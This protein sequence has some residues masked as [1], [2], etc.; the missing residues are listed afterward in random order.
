MA[1]GRKFV[2]FLCLLA[3][4]VIV[5]CASYTEEVRE[6][7]SLYRQ[8]SYE[9]ALKKLDELSLKEESK[10][11]LLYRLEKAMIL[12]RL[13]KGDEARKLLL[14]A[15]KI[16]DELYTTSITKTAASFIVNDSSTDYEGEDFEKVAIH[17]QLALS[18]LGEGQLQQARVEAKAINSRLQ[19]INQKY[20]ADS[21]NRYQ[22]DAFA[23]YLSGLIFE[24]KGEWDDAIIDY[25]KALEL[26]ETGYRPFYVGPVPEGLIKSL[27]HLAEKRN[28][29]E[30]VAA[31]Q[32]KYPTQ[33]ASIKKSQSPQSAEAR[34]SEQMGSLAV[35][36]E[37]GHVAVKVNHEFVLP[38]AGQI[39]R[40]SFPVISKKKLGGVRTHGCG[41]G[42]GSVSHR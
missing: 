18:F 25:R 38:I 1:I 9:R 41:N 20:D 15:D 27:Y 3:T 14:E 13:G 40:F 35:I 4:L 30:I 21:K 34:G 17:T 12:D 24:A 10:N 7:R 6:V 32:T 37:V 31:I 19:E 22:N 28:R 2:K 23:L 5:S 33:I 11:R 36:H 16:V 42:Q 29:R 8:G 26:C 39:V